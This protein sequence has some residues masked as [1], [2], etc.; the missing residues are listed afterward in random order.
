MTQTV[1]TITFNSAG[2]R[3]TLDAH[4]AMDGVPRPGLLLIHGASGIR[5]GN[6]Y[7]PHIAGL[8]A[9]H[10]FATLLVRYFEATD[11]TYADDA[12]IWQNFNRWL[13]GI[14]DAVTEAIGLPEIDGNRI[15]LVGY[16]LGGY[17]AVAQGSRDPRVKAVVE[18]AGGIDP[19]FARDVTRLPPTL[20]IH[21]RND[22]RVPFER[23]SELEIVLER[24]GAAHETKYFLGEGHLL[25]PA[26]AIASLNAALEFLRKH[27]A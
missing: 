22:R 7:I 16:S 24:V 6:S 21:G 5:G 2:R 18:L 23:A 15:G 9:A 11:T 14:D 19:E 26:A 20:V 25:S 12:T 13:Q 4:F 10:G 17:L 8:L 1:R 3:V 27:L